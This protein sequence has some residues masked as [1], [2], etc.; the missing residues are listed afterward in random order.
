MGCTLAPRNKS[1]WN[2][3]LGK[4]Q[5]RDS[6]G[7]KTPGTTVGV[8]M[9]SCWT[10]MTILLFLQLSRVTQVVSGRDRMWA[11]VLH[12]PKS[13][14][15]P[16]YFSVS[17]ARWQRG[18]CWHFL[19]MY[20]WQLCAWWSWSSSLKMSFCFWRTLFQ[21]L[22]ICTWSPLFT[23]ASDHQAEELECW[24]RKEQKCVSFSHAVFVRYLIEPSFFAPLNSQGNCACLSLSFNLL[25]V[26]GQ[27]NLMKRQLRGYVHDERKI[28]YLRAACF[29]K[30]DFN[31][32]N[33]KYLVWPI[34]LFV[35]ELFYCSIQL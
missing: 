12:A 2:R 20:L 10:L 33:K 30:W 21:A 26:P 11:Q 32:L 31:V 34:M 23:A 22:R 1:C 14:F 8:Y 6:L 24:W 19:S 16:L 7:I 28:N 5:G 25:F 17:R 4:N 13:G 3:F 18:E 27:Q 9:L 35:Q 29:L 15:F